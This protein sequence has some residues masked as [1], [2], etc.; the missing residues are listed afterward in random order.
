MMMRRRCQHGGDLKL[1]KSVVWCFGSVV[2]HG[3]ITLARG[4]RAPLTIAAAV[5]AIAVGGY[6]GQEI[7]RVW[8]NVNNGA[9]HHLG[10][11][12]LLLLLRTHVDCLGHSLWLCSSTQEL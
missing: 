10:S 3:E 5:A 6:A 4:S 7:E 8:L 11:L 9:T 12:L 1:W 2:L